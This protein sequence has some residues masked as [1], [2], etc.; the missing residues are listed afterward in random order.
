MKTDNLL[1]P[2]PSPNGTLIVPAWA[3]PYV[4]AALVVVQVIGAALALEG[5]WTIERTFMVIQGILSL[6]VGGALGGLRK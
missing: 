6:L 1:Q 5:P 2:A 3:V 4:L